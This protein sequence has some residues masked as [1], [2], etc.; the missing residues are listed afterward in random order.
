[1]LEPVK[2]RRRRS[3]ARTTFW[4][5]GL[6]LAACAIAAGAALLLWPEPRVESDAEAL[7]HVVQPGYAGSVSSIVVRRSDGTIVPVAVRHGRLW[8]ERKLAVGEQ[9]TVELEVRRPG[10][11]GWLVGRTAKAT[12][13]IRTPSARLVGRW[14][15]VRPGEPLVATFDAPVRTVAL[16]VHGQ[17]RMLHFTRAR[18]TVALGP[19]QPGQRSGRISIGAV[20]RVWERIPKPSRLTWFPA[21]PQAQALVEPAAGTA[22]DPDRAITLTFS[23]PV[24]TIFGTRLP[25]V[26]PS[27]PGRWQLLDTHT[28]TFTPRGL[29]YPLSGHLAVHLPE[30]VGLAQAAGS[31]NIG[32]LEW[33]VR[34][35][36]VLR[37]EQLL[38]QA[39][40]LPL[41]WS[42]AA[43]ATPTV[44]SELA[45]TAEPPAGRFR[46]R[47]ENT[48]HEL[49]ALWRTGKWNAIVRGAVMMFED[50]HHLD[51]D[52]FVGPKVWGAL[53]ADTLAGRKRTDGYSYV[54]VHREV[55]QS[56]TLWHDG[57]TVL[58]S[59]GNTGVPAA[60][61][62]LGTFPVFEHIPIGTMSGTN[63][64]GS[65]Y[66]DPGIRYISYFNHGD[67]IHAFN[68]SSFGTPQSLGCVELPL[69][70]AAKV[71]P[72]TP[73]GVLVTVEN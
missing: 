61:T 72:Y 12:L 3:S 66:H 32:S 36:T 19:V 15:E 39:G 51:V 2:R 69:A 45:A 57:K 71:W 48:P 49:H 73:I 63:P 4:V 8:P 24:R 46:W 60:P 28:L 25:T 6:T 5:V 10:W 13:G 42:P 52:G 67:A 9:L 62:Q 23:R 47:Y 50:T 17:P 59:P 31:G 20:P 29:G 58:R 21:R 1:M 44:R 65:H 43:P 40:Y 41:L 37:L 38:A 18:T 70:A 22:L 64:D 53:L 35:G 26:T 55:P 7:A 56:L 34:H 14:L 11:A 33:D 27:V 16:R 68:R 30:R 54:Y